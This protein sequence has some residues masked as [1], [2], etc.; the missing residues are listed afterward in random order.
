[1][2]RITAIGLTRR[3]AGRENTP[4]EERNPMNIFAT[5]ILLALS[6]TLW[7]TP[8]VAG[9]DDAKLKEATR[10][11]ESGAKAVGSGIEST[12]KGVG[13]TVVEGAKTAGEKIKEAGKAAEPEAKTAWGQ[14]K[15]GAWSFGQSVKNFFTRLVGN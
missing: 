14:F 3:A 5:T 1:L 6:L 2:P 4:P 7:S 10:E 12:A 11:V 8:Q 13:H 9:A 15:D